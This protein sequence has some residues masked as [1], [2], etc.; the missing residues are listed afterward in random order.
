MEGV[1]GSKMFQKEKTAHVRDVCGFL[2]WCCVADLL[3]HCEFDQ[4][5]EILVLSE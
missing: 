1:E 5:L 2:I 3:K 4:C